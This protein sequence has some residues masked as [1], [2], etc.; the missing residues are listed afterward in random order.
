MANPSHALAY[1]QMAHDLNKVTPMTIIVN[2][3]HES[4]DSPKGSLALMHSVIQAG[5]G[6]P[7][8]S[9]RAEAI[10][11]EALAELDCEVCENGDLL[12]KPEG[13]HRAYALSCSACSRDSHPRKPERRI[14]TCD[15]CGSPTHGRVFCPSV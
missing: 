10:Y 9:A 7:E 1:A 11:H 15:N 13:D 5:I 3:K 12:V 2:G 8:W 14:V 6:D 4:L